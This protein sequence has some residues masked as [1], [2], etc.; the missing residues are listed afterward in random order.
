MLA[1]AIESGLVGSDLEPSVRKSSGFNIV[2]RVD[3]NIEDPAALF[4]NEMLMTFNQRIEMLRASQ[5]EHLELF[6]SD[7]FLQI[8]INGSKAHIGQTFAHLTVNLICS[9]V[10]IVVFNRLPDDLQLFRISWLPIDLRHG[11]ALRSSTKDC[12]VPALIAALAR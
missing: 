4:T 8:T 9:R 10:G 7:Q 3:Q 6:I 12:R 1:R 2:L 5:H 11:Y